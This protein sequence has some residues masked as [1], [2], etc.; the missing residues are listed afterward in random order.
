MREG[1]NFLAI[2]TLARAFHALA[3]VDGLDPWDPKAL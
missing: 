2:A 1:E 3:K